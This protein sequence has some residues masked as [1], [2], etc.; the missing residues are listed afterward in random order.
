MAGSGLG[1]QENAAH[2]TVCRRLRDHPRLSPKR[3]SF[4]FPPE[5][6]GKTIDPEAL[7]REAGSFNMAWLYSCG[8]R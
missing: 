3:Q 7:F 2:T 4:V 6:G 8:V 5:P 1:E